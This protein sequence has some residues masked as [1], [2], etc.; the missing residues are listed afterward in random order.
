MVQC[1]ETTY[2]AHSYCFKKRSWEDVFD[3]V[4]LSKIV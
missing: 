1:S 3:Q 2:A 4:E